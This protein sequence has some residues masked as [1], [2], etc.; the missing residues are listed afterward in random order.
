GRKM[1][2][3]RIGDRPNCTAS[4]PV[5]SFL[6]TRLLPVVLSLLIAASAVA[7]E[8][9]AGRFT[10]HF[11]WRGAHAATNPDDHG[12][13][14]WWDADSWDVRGDSTFLAVASLGKGFHTDVHKAASAD[15]ADA[16]TEDGHVVGGDG[17]PGVGIM[18][19]DFQG[20]NSARLRNP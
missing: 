15:P 4:R 7:G 5:L 1:R 14:V 6:M 12:T 19:T 9:V 10:E 17:S 2:R 18:H 16:R 11:A 20:I 8:V 13:T 3:S